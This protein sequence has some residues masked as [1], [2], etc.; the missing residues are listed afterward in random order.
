MG[1]ATKR[2][3]C[4][5]LGGDHH[6]NGVRRPASARKSL[7]RGTPQYPFCVTPE[8]DPPQAEEIERAL[9]D[10]LA[11]AAAAPDAWWQAGIEEALEE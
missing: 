5:P 1:A 7:D 11:A 10:A 6:P 4:R 9:A 3:V 8:T 2:I